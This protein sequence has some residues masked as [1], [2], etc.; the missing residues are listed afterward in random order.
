[1][2]AT[3]AR[4][5]HLLSGGYRDLCLR[6]RLKVKRARERERLRHSL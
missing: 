5:A 3:T 4:A 6:N 2:A 1:M